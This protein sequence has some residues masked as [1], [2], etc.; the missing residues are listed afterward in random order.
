M[1]Y[2]LKHLHIAILHGTSVE[3]CLTVVDAFRF[4]LAQLHVQFF[5]NFIALA[6]HCSFLHLFFSLWQE[7]VHYRFFSLLSFPPSLSLR[8][9][10]YH[11]LD[12]PLSFY[13]SVSSSGVFC[14]LSLSLSSVF[15]CFFL[16]GGGGDSSLFF[17]ISPFFSSLSFFVSMSTPS[18]CAVLGSQVVHLFLSSI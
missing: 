10:L 15:V 14:P 5:L 18:S 4:P 7:I 13:L 2:L 6:F 16:G 8:I 3:T 1:V 12:F 17:I 11:F 9:S